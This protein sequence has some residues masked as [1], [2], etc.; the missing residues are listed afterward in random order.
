[1]VYFFV[2]GALGASLL[3]ASAAT[4]IAQPMAKAEEVTNPAVFV[5]PVLYRSV[6]VD[7]PTGVETESLDWRRANA[8]VGQFKRGHVDVLKWEEEQAA[9]R[10]AMPAGSVQPAPASGHQHG[11]KP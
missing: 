9:R 3:V 1:M 6:F 4:V 11:A 10:K 8:D 2:R 5:P 7:T